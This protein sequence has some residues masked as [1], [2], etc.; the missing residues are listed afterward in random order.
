MAL[1]LPE[2]ST[3]AMTLFLA[4]LARVVPAGTHAVL[5]L[6]RAG[7]HV[8]GDLVVPANLTLVHL[9]PYSPE[10]NP[11]ERVW[12]YLR[13]RWLSHC[14]LAGYDAVLD[15][16]C[17]AWNAL[18]AEPGKAP[19]A[20]RLPVAARCGHQFMRSVLS[21]WTALPLQADMDLICVGPL[22]TSIR[23]HPR[24]SGRPNGKAARAR[25]YSW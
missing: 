2:V 3:G 13:E 19:L 15:A 11:V 1:A 22:R 4:E 6:D 9:P 7:W 18:R 17:A 25:L 24:S 16:A 5:V 12:L 20:H 14:V 10:L 21:L 8:S 23:R